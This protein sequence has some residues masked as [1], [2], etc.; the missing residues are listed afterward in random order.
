MMKQNGT[1]VC[2]NGSDSAGFW[3]AFA[4]RN[5]I[6]GTLRFFKVTAAEGWEELQLD[7]AGSAS[8]SIRGHHLI[9]DYC[10][11]GR[12]KWPIPLGVTITPEPICIY[13]SD[14]DPQPMSQSLGAITV[15]PMLDSAF[16]LGSMGVDLE[17]GVATLELP[18]RLEKVVDRQL[19]A[20]LQALIANLP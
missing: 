5:A 1:A 7:L 3:D 19:E 14:P 16:S 10:G 15:S 2:F 11:T 18:P 12:P 20:T 8:Y 6:S 9:D 13:C 17:D 4:Q